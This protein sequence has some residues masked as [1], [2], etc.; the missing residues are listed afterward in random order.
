QRSY[1]WVLWACKS[2]KVTYWHVKAF[3]NEHTCERNNNYNVELK[4]VSAAMIGDLFASKYLNPR[5]IIHHKDIIFEM[6]EQHDIHLSYNK[7]YRLKEHALNQVFGG[8]WEYVQ[9]DFD[10]LMAKLKETY[11]E[12][13]DEL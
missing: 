3:V 9:R 4:L 2:N 10:L 12:V 8:P 6:R 5:P 11:R 7:A 1:G 13:Y